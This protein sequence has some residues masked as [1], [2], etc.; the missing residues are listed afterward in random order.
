M[1]MNFKIVLG[2]IIALTL[3]IAAASPI[4]VPNL[5]LTTKIQ[6]EVD[7]VY[8]FFG[9]QE[10]DNQIIGLWRNS[11]DPYE[12]NLH[13]ISYFIV[14]NVTNRSDKLAIIDEFEASAAQEILV[15]NGT[16]RIGS[17]RLGENISIS[18]SNVGFG[19]SI[20]NRIVTDF[21][22]MSRYYPG[23]SQYLS[24]KASRLVALT[25]IVEISNIA[26]YDALSSGNI[27][28]FGRVRGRPLGEGTPSTAFCLKQIQLQKIEKD[29]LYN[30]V[31][32]E[33]QM[34]RIDVN[35]ID[36]CIET[37]R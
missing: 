31:L 25:G 12:Y 34:W 35:Q 13:I 27:Y 28:L 19:V 24:P 30:A 6:M 11:S 29:F 2:N 5:K 33:N 16:N 14:L 21:R 1:G 20:Q 10:F 8:A 23:W 4:L 22:D 37:R 7:V 36:V 3:G 9:I 18:P 32:S 17:E 15:Y 26:A